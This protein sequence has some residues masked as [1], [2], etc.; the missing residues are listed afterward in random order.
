MSAYLQAFGCS[1]GADTPLH[2]PV[3]LL[4]RLRQKL[5]LPLYTNGRLKVALALLP[6]TRQHE[7]ALHATAREDIAAPVLEQEGESPE[8]AECNGATSLLAFNT[9]F[10]VLL[11]L[12]TLP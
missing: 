6:Q 8:I 3:S 9:Y 11:L 2:C 5:L 7:R 12:S 1:R 10:T 4:T